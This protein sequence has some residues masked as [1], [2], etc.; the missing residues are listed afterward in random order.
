MGV[1]TVEL[2]GTLIHKDVKLERPT[3]MG[4]PTAQVWPEASF[5]SYFNTVTEGP[6]RLQAENA[7]VR[8]ANIAIQRINIDPDDEEEEDE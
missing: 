6:I 2:N 5:P 7:S 8:F 3:F 1:A 4:F